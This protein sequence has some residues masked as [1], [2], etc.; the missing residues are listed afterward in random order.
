MSF[1][2]KEIKL[3]CE[4]K[5]KS[6]GGLNVEDMKLLLNM[7]GSRNE[8]I[9]KLKELHCQSVSKATEAIKATKASK[10]TE[11]DFYYS[12]SGTHSINGKIIQQ[13]VEVTGNKGVRKCMKNGKT[14]VIA[15]TH[16]EIQQL[17]KMPLLILF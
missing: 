9:T 5:S 11:A 16:G 17:K 12:S 3:A 7:D 8:L 2:K 14:T 6:Q 15:L 10:A 13:S 4:G 1:T